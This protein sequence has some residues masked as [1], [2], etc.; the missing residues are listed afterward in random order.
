MSVRLS[1]CFYAYLSF[2][3]PLS[4]SLLHRCL[5]CPHTPKVS[6]EH[7]KE[8]KRLELEQKAAAALSEATRS[9]PESLL[10]PNQ[11]YN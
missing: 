5:E 1:V 8:R 9:K 4:L 3:L 2:C 7:Q 6:E 11:P 10:S